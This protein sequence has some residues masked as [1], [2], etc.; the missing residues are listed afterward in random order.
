M[1]CVLCCSVSILWF[2]FHRAV[3]LTV[4]V[5]AHDITRQ[6]SSSYRIDVKFYHIHPGYNAKTLENDIMLLQVHDSGRMHTCQ[7]VS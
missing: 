7:N 1:F 6:E 2:P 4:V 5:G 3:N